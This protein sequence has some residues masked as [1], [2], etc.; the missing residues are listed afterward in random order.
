MTSRHVSSSRFGILLILSFLLMSFSPAADIDDEP[1]RPNII[2]LVADDLG[3]GEIVTDHKA[4]IPTPH[5]DEIGK[6]GILFRAGYVTAPNCSASRAGMMSGR[7]QTRFGHEFNPTEAKHDDPRAGIPSSEVTIAEL[8]RGVGYTTGLIGK[9]HLGG[10]LGAHPMRHGFDEFYGFLHEGHYFVPS[11]YDGV[12]TWL[13]REELPYGSGGKSAES[14][15]AAEPLPNATGRTPQDRRWVSADSQLVYS[16]VLGYT[17]PAYD[18]GNPIMRNGQP[19]EE[20]EYLTDAITRESVSFIDRHD[21]KPFFLFVSYNAVHSPMQATD[22]YMEKFDYIDDIHRR[23]FAGMLSHLDSSVGAIMSKLREEGLEEN[24]LVFFISDNGGPTRELT[25]SNLPLRGGKSDM[26]EGGIRVPFLAQW[27]GHL[28]AGKIEER[29]VSSVDI[30]ATAASV[31]GAELPTDRV[32]DGVNMIPYLTGGK[33]GVLHDALFWRQ[34][35][36]TAVQVDGWKLVQN[37]RD[38]RSAHAWELYHL[39]EDLREETDLAL[40]EPEK[41]QDLRGVWAQLNAEMMA[42]NWTRDMSVL[43]AYRD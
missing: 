12:T 24:T 16:T 41:V 40:A 8:L 20:E 32:V 43:D 38:P 14:A 6:N 11:P 28:P 42:P 17:E 29:A 22:A 10:T 31:A 34:G 5:I 25:S 13:R 15:D 33:S 19:I 21:D 1:E 9:W 39:A 26:Y 4:R 27:K 2:V 23:I 18:A 30:Y 37:D 36:G 35:N 7:F 3:Y